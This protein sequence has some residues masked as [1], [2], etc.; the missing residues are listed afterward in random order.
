[1]RVAHV[2]GLSVVSGGLLAGC[3][4]SDPPPLPTEVEA[5]QSVAA[6]SERPQTFATSD[7]EWAWIA[8]NT[9]PGFAGLYYASGR[10]E[11]VPTY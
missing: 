7:D 1:M 4:D 6:S 3:A 10:R 5:V 9:A 2:V 8:R 11:G